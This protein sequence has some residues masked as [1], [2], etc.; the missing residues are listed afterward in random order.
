[1]KVFLAGVMQGNKSEHGIRAQDYR[2]TITDILAGVMDDIEVIDPDK[3]DPYRL[4][5]NREEAGEMFLKYC[6][7]AREVDLLIAYIPEASM[8]TA[9][10]MWNAYQ[11]NVPIVTISPLR[12]NWTVRL[13]SAVVFTDLDEFRRVFDQDL[14]QKLTNHGSPMP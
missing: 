4:S 1:V 11:A 13:L 7:I 6:K 5:Y 8:G 3:T 14:L 9:I 2:S 12:H 10:E